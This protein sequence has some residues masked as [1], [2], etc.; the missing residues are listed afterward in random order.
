VLGH[1]VIL[2][3]C[4]TTKIVYFFHSGKGAVQM[5]KRKLA[6]LSEGVELGCDPFRPGRLD[7]S[8][9]KWSTKR[10]VDEMLH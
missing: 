9:L 6:L 8:F 2:Q 1:F 3:F 4:Q 10:Q 7:Q 5:R